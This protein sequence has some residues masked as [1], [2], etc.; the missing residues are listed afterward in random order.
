MPIR[1]ILPY[2]TG[3][4]N[5]HKMARSASTKVNRAISMPEVCL[6]V[7]GEAIVV[8]VAPKVKLYVKGKNID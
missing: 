8:S 7:A 2:E 3:Y 1:I 6:W 4:N 5:T